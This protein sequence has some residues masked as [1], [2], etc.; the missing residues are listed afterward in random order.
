MTRS[1]YRILEQVGAGQFG[2]VFCAIAKNTGTIVALKDLNQ[3]SYPTKKFLREILYLVTLQ[4]PN[5]V[6][7]NGFEHHRRGRYLILDYCEGGTLRDLMDSQ[8][9]LGLP[10]RLKLIVDVLCGLDHAHRRGIVHCDI[11]PENILLEVHSQGWRA[12]LTDFGIARLMEEAAGV[13]ESGGYTGSPAYM[14]PERFYGKYSYASDLYAI[15][16]LLY[17]LIVGQRPFSGLPAQLMSAHMSGFVSI[18]DSVPGDLRS[19]IEI[20]LRK[21]PQRRFSNAGEMLDS[22]NRAIQKLPAITNDDPIYITSQLPINSDVRVIFTKNIFDNFTA[23]AN[24]ETYIYYTNNKK[25]FRERLDIVEKFIKCLIFPHKVIQVEPHQNG[26]WIWTGSQTQTFLYWSTDSLEVNLLAKFSNRAV[27]S[28]LHPPAQSLALHQFK[29]FMVLKLP[30]T[31]VAG[32]NCIPSQPRQL[33]WID[34]RY[35]LAIFQEENSTKFQ[36]F[37]RRGKVMDGLTLPV[38]TADFTIHKFCPNFLVALESDRV[39]TLIVIN[40]KPWRLTRI[41]LANIPDF[42][43]SY[44]Q[45]FILAERGGKVTFL[46]IQTYRLSYC[47]I[48]TSIKCVSSLDKNRFIVI[49]EEN[50]LQIIEIDGVGIEPTDNRSG[51]GKTVT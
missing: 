32:L 26:C 19:I 3:L 6:A 9:P 2:R 45:G 16:I 33:M 14:A 31:R 35:G 13:R 42:I 28:D 38:R 1:H 17:E 27:F 25:I 23:F 4:H 11:K 46:N 44:G 8:T 21:L 22:L 51:E 15:G 20:A 39:S 49:N 18:P 41:P 5:I 29:L 50:Q 48:S 40:L 12:K 30:Q 10:Y 34:R 47:Q 36:L 7:F 37:N 24:N 43:C